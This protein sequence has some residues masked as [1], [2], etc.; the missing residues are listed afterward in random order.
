MKPWY[1]SRDDAW[2]VTLRL[3]DG[4]RKLEKHREGHANEAET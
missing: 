2:F 3:P 1:K 4:T